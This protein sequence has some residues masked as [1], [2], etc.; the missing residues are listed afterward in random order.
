M[1]TIIRF[2]SLKNTHRINTESVSLYF[3]KATVNTSSMKQKST[4]QNRLEKS[5]EHIIHV[6]NPVIQTYTMI[7]ESGEQKHYS[8]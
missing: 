4:K 1:Q 5:G 7:R 8:R 2:A 6:P 3:P